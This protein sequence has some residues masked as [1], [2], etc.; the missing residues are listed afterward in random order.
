MQVKKKKE[1]RT[2][3]NVA[4][5]KHKSSTMISRLTSTLSLSRDLWTSMALEYRYKLNCMHLSSVIHILL[6]LFM[7]LFTACL[8]SL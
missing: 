7:C 1:L 3:G 6:M 4:M 5:W 2:E 8:S